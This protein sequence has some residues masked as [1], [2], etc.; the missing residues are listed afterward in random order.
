MPATIVLA[1][2]FTGPLPAEFV[3]RQSPRSAEELRSA[4]REA[5]QQT[6]PRQRPD[7]A[8]VIPQA[9]QLY[10]EL[11]AAEG[12]S[13][14]ERSKLRGRLKVRLEEVRDRLLRNE[15]ARDR[16]AARVRY[17][18]RAAVD[19]RARPAEAG[20]YEHYERVRGSSATSLAGP[21]D[22]R[23]ARRLIDLIQNTIA[24]ESWEINGGRGSIRY[25]DLY[26]ALVVRQTG[27]VHH[28][29]NAGLGQLRK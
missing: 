8:T 7:Y 20:H 21:L 3:E 14:A 11:A 27:E 4:Y 19:A 23:Q 15:I 24:P 9:V 5:L 6:T 18:A 12:L 25:Y 28:Q 13:H 29:L 22:A 17:R 1:L 10:A 2:A 16:A 26:Q